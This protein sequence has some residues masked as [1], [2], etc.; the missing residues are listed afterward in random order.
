M[1]NTVIYFLVIL[2][3]SSCGLPEPEKAV[4]NTS[5]SR[6]L[7]V[8]HLS[9][10]AS[11]VDILADDNVVL[12]N[13]TYL[14]QSS[15]LSL[16]SS[17]LNVK[18]N[19]AGTSTSVINADI[20]LTSAYSTV[21]A[22]D[23]LGSIGAI[24]FEDELSEPSS[25]K[26]KVRIAHGAPGVGAVDV[27]VVPSDNNC[28]SLAGQQRTLSNVPFK[29]A[30]SY[31]EVEDGA[32]DICITPTNTPGTVAISEDNLIFYADTNVTIIAVEGANNPSALGLL[33]L[34]DSM[35]SESAIQLGI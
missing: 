27:Y 14:E 22:T 11:A 31:L 4:N 12:N 35:V 34:I 19:A 10:D 29:A 15:Y 6:Y 32:Y 8:L 5:S 33:M 26:V 3:C 18:V 24:I 21:L 17:A 16:D 7:R 30:S 28:T 20:E 13:V 23:Y 25:G 2:F 9:P 1:T